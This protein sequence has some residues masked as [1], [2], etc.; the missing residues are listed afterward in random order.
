[1]EIDTKYA[2]ERFRGMS[3]EELLEETALR[4]EEYVPLVRRML[5]GEALARGIAPDELAACRRAAAA[6]EPETQIDFPAL[7][8]SAMDKGHVQE[9]VDALRR[10]GIPA[11]AREIDTRVF[12]GS[13][14]AVG[15]WGLFVPGPHAAAAGRRLEALF[16]SEHA[17]AAPGCGGCGA[18]CGG[19]DEAALASG[20]WDEDGDWWKTGAPG[21]DEQ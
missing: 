8:T 19:E 17:G 10:E 7:I 11:V 15:R 20:E 16:P 14:C 9:L 21:E 6:P 5:E 12:H 18:T 3:R 13:G 2:L 4:A 1:M